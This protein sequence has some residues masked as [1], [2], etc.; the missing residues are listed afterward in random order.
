MK[1]LWLDVETTGIDPKTND[2]VQVAALVEIDGNIVEEFSGVC[3]PHD[4]EA[5]EE[6]ALAVNGLTLEQ[7]SRFS[8]PTIL[9]LELCQLFGKYVDK[10]DRTDKFT[11]AGMKV[12]FDAQFMSEFFRKCGDAYWGSWCNW[13]H[14]D[15]CAFAR[16]LRYAG[17]LDIGNDKLSTICR[18]VG[19][20]LQNAHDAMADILATREA[21]TRLMAK[22]LYYPTPGGDE[23]GKEGHDGS[24]D[25]I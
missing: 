3:R 11:L 18:S 22:Y 24:G 6:S 7:V 9:H 14:V 17:L 16:I 13:R 5:V 25:T 21:M 10:Y 20:D 15:L 4:L 19:V 8:P 12:D 23:R 1:T 2:V